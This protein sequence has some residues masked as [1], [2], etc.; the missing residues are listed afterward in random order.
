ME[1]LYWL[2]R[3]YLKQAAPERIAELALPF[4]QRAG[5]A[6]EKASA[7]VSQWFRNLLALLVPY[8]NKLDELPEKA[9]LVFKF[10]P[11]AALAAPDNAA[12]LADEKVDSVIKAFADRLNGEPTVTPERFKAIMNE[13]KDATG[14]KG[15]ELFHPVRIAIIGSHSGPEFDKLIPVLEQGSSLPLPVPVK[16]TRERVTEFMAQWRKR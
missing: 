3:H 13:V 9:A 5:L 4:F 11:S 8:V 12:T 14:A 2:N 1:K 6:P 15:K 7:E 16:S 10:D